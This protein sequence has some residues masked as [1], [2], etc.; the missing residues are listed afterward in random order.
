MGFSSSRL[1]RPRST[2]DTHSSSIDRSRQVDHFRRCL[3]GYSCGREVSGGSL[4]FAQT[5]RQVVMLVLIQLELLPL[6]LLLDCWTWSRLSADRGCG[7][8]IRDRRV[9]APY[10]MDE[11]RAQ[12]CRG[13]CRLGIGI[14]R[15]S[16]LIRSSRKI[17]PP[18]L[19][20]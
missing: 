1:D 15:T 8:W 19:D 7:C 3:P 13:D 11:I 4:P 14:D 2:S 5:F 9:I 18:D 16:R 20:L 10:A 12:S 17:E 6:D